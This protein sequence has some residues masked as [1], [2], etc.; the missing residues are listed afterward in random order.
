MTSQIKQQPLHYIQ[1]G[2]GVPM[3][4]IHGNPD[5]SH[6]WHRLMNVLSDDFHCIAPDLPG[7]GQSDVPDGFDYSLSQQAECI[8]HFVA[9]LALEQPL[10]LVVHDV[11]AFFGLAWAIRFPERVRSI[12]IFNTAFSP[13][14]RWHLLG[15]IWR[16]PVLGELSLKAMN[17][18]GF[19][20]NLRKAAPQ[21]PKEDVIASFD[22]LTPRTHKSLLKLYRAMSPAKFKGWDVR[23]H[24]LA[25]DL[26]MQV[27][28]GAKDPY[29]DQAFAYR[30][31]TDQVHLFEDNSHWLPAEQPQASADLIRGFIEKLPRA[32]KS[33]S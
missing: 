27:L 14:Y 23:L 17:K 20:A 31:G 10:H 21:Y 9:S 1:Q 5:T 26:P 25:K 30:F 33:A 19:I 15:R 3:L 8:E 11:G 28:W 6:M 13:Q 18:G 29:I 12:T 16:T 22:A 4:M 32:L 7:Y 2:S 24:A